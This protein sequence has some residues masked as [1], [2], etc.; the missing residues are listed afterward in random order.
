[1]SDAST[2]ACR[3]CA[4]FWRI[5]CV[6]LT[7][8]PSLLRAA[9]PPDRLRAFRRVWWRLE[10]P[11]IT[12]GRYLAIR[13]G[14]E[15][16]QR[17]IRLAD[18]THVSSTSAGLLP[19]HG[20]ALWLCNT[21]EAVR[22]EHV[23]Q[24]WSE[25]RHTYEPGVHVLWVH[26]SNASGFYE[27][28]LKRVQEA[29]PAFGQSTMVEEQPI[30]LVTVRD[31]SAP[32][33][34]EAVENWEPSQVFEYVAEDCEMITAD[35]KTLKKIV[36][37]ERITG[38]ALVAMQRSDVMRVFEELSIHEKNKIW[39]CVQSLKTSAEGSSA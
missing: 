8:C 11:R 6:T 16:A 27:E 36:V 34:D 25:E 19:S 37:G 30:Q 35:R 31:P 18:V 29:N 10:P 28:L 33:P 23:A 20:F 2:A 9:G 38:K 13:T 22:V 24:R 12:S 3:R 32:P 17:T 21:H 4:S 39:R 5:A 7:G 15:H 26:V 14:S 1:M